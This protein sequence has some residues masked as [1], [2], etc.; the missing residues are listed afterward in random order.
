MKWDTRYLGTVALVLYALSMVLPAADVRYS[1]ESAPQTV[2]GF[3]MLGL[4]LIGFPMLF[5]GESMGYVCLLGVCCNV[6]FIAAY[7]YF[8]VERRIALS[9][10]FA[11]LA[12]IGAVVVAQL[13]LQLKVWGF[14]AW[15]M[16]F[17]LLA[18]A[19]AGQVLEQLRQAPPI[20]SAPAMAA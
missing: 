12:A 9:A 2:V 3:F 4:S 18:I 10:M 17:G 1:A 5:Q 7:L 6:L 11:L 15:L 8:V 19:A 20:D 16:S 14:G 13:N